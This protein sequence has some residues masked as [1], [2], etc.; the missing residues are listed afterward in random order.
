MNHKLE[1]INILKENNFLLKKIF[2]LIEKEPKFI[3]LT[4]LS[5]ELKKSNQTIKY[6]LISNYEPEKDFKKKNGKIYID[7]RIVSS[8]R[9]HYEKK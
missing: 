8:I 1:I 6:H 3:Q 2:N 9:R 4:Q 7:N 5:E